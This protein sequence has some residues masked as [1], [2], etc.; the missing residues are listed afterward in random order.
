MI[1]GGAFFQVPLIEY[2]R[3][4]GLY[5]ITVDYLPNNPG[6]KLS[7][8]YHNISTVEKES[9]LQ[10]ARELRVDAISAFASDPAAPAAAYVCEKMGLVGAS[11]E[12]VNTLTDKSLFRKFLKDH[13]FNCPWFVAGEDP[14]DL[15]R[16][17]PGG[18]AVL[19]PVDSS[20]SKGIKV[21][22]DKEDLVNN[23]GF[24]LKHSRSGRVIL[25][26]FI[27][28]KEPHI[29]GDG[30]VVDGKVVF[31][32]PGE[33]IYSSNN[34]LAP[35]GTIAPGFYHQDI[36]P[37]LFRLVQEAVSKVGFGTG[38]INVEVFRDPNDNLWIME[39]GARN[40]GNFIPELMQQAS[41]FALIRANVDAL[42]GEPVPV[43]NNEL[44]RGHFAQVILLS[45][46][47]GKYIGLNLPREFRSKVVESHIRCHAGDLVP[48]Y[49]HSGHAAGALIIRLD[50]RADEQALRQLLAKQD[51][52]LTE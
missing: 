2:A 25:E 19:K 47:G 22:R 11:Y 20:G 24:A 5:V 30:F 12:S 29:H 50:G 4:K 1:L 14:D 9:I 46:K 43:H 36:L 21:I 40:G 10:L 7:D 48:P 28:A 33:H 3:H 15:L 44:I 51:F 31:L 52:I 6:H 41:G 45:S 18:K 34:P 42:L 13:Q 49:E 26:Q 27:E 39:I 35:A 38:G 37:E 16:G 8:E 23:F 17:Y 32:C